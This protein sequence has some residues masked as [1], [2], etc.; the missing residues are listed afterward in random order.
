MSVAAPTTLG[1]LV[2]LRA[3]VP[4][5]PDDALWTARAVWGEAPPSSAAARAREHALL[6]SIWLR[7]WA[8]FTDDRIGRGLAPLWPAFGDLA[9]AHSQPVNPAWR[10]GG[11][12][13]AHPDSVDAHETRRAHFSA[14]EWD[15]IPPAIRGVVVGMLSGSLALV[16]WPAVDFASPTLWAAHGA[17]WSTRDERDATFPDAVRARTPGQEYVKVA[18]LDRGA[19]VPVSTLYSRTHAD[20]KV[21]ASE[22][23]IVAPLAIALALFAG[24]TL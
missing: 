17:R 5:E 18:G 4:L 12:F 2:A 7:R 6:I 13:D 10:N 1:L 16:G 8:M 15:E 19:N 22:R 24:V 14:Y 20:P 3:R 11:R 21:Y 23:S 9:R